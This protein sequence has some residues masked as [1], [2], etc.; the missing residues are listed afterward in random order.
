MNSHNSDARDAI[1]KGRRRVH[2]ESAVLQAVLAYLNKLGVD[3]RNGFSSFAEPSKIILALCAWAKTLAEDKVETSGNSPSVRKGLLSLGCVFEL[4]ALGAS[5]TS[6]PERLGHLSY[7]LQPCDVS[8]PNT[9]REETV[10]SWFNN[11]VTLEKYSKKPFS[12]YVIKYETSVALASA[13]A[14]SLEH[15]DF[16]LK[17]S[18]VLPLPMKIDKLKELTELMDRVVGRVDDSKLEAATQALKDNRVAIVK[19]MQ[20]HLL[21]SCDYVTQSA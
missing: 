4:R 15:L 2:Q 16:F 21:K 13:N 9:T 11:M 1:I 19:E 6:D 10:R 3:D 12:Q 14:K 5:T 7:W 8:L 18:Q 20:T 17:A